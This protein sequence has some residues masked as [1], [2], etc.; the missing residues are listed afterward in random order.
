MKMK[1]NTMM[2]MVEIHLQMMTLVI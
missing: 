1:I 2:K